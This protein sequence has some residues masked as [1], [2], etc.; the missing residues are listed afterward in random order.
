M[1]RSRLDRR[2]T[3]NLAAALLLT[4]TA[5]TI[6]PFGNPTAALQTVQAFHLHIKPGGYISAC[7]WGFDEVDLVV[8]K[9][10]TNPT[11]QG[12]YINE[13]GKKNSDSRVISEAS[14]QNF[15]QAG[16]RLTL[17]SPQDQLCDAAFVEDYNFYDYCVTFSGQRGQLRRNGYE[18]SFAA[19]RSVSA[20]THHPVIFEE[21]KAV[22]G[23]GPN[24]ADRFQPNP[25]TSLLLKR[26]IGI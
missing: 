23:E 19:Y 13:E 22:C 6:V 1:I 25:S 2:A 5:A 24:G 9:S 16:L 4:V 11:V 18:A 21:L 14:W 3:N 20:V 26:T 12:V 8:E 10:G 17:A 15:L 7:A